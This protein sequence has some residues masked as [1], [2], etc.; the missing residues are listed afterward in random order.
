MP[1]K[2][3]T[4]G[5][6]DRAAAAELSEPDDGPPVIAEPIEP[7]GPMT[8]GQLVEGARDVLDDVA[9]SARRMVDRGRYRKVRISRKGKPLLPDIPV[10]AFAAVQAASLAAGAG[11][12]RVLVANVGAKLFFDIDVVNE[13]DKYFER[14]KTA[15]LDGDLD[16]AQEA[17]D[18]AARM[19][20]M[21]PG[22][23]L[24]LG[25]LSR[26]RG[27]ADR[28]RRHLERARTLDPLGDVGRRAE[29]ILLAIDS[30]PR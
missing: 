23:F 11:L 2:L 7:G 14:G 26:L 17:L 1:E 28:A 4:E 24:Q 9:T 10:A 27:D 21:H 6:L 3:R 16:R 19:D 30:R 20:D 12:A 29:E 22:V 15:L 8:I 5:A 25:V 13:A 18:V